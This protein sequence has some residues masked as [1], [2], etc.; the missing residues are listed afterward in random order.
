M[1][2]A[3]DPTDSPGQHHGYSTDLPGQH[4]GYSTEYPGQHH[5]YSTDLPGYKTEYQ[6]GYS[7]LTRTFLLAGTI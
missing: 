1:A 7:V 6:P 4:H 5:G 2:T 3:P